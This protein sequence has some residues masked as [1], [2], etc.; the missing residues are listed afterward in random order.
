MGY[1][2]AEFPYCSHFF[3]LADP[4]FHLF[5]L[6]DVLEGDYL[7]TVRLLLFRGRNRRKVER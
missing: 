5:N 1:G 3:S 4:F 7:A 2:G 6:A